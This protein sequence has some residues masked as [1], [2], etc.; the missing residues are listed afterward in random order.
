[1]VCAVDLIGFSFRAV[2]HP[3]DH[4]MRRIFVNRDGDRFVMSVKRYE[5]AS[6][7]KANAENVV[8]MDGRFM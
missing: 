7:I 8:R 1:M 5:R 2:I 3:E 6:S 4:V